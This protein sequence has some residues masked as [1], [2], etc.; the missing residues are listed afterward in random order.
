MEEGIWT[1]VKHRRHREQVKQRLDMVTVFVNNLPEDM[2]ETLGTG[3]WARPQ[4]KKK[5]VPINTPIG[6]KRRTSSSRFGELTRKETSY[7]D[8]VRGAASRRT[9]PDIPIIKGAFVDNEWLYR[10]AVATFKDDI[11]LG[12]SFNSFTKE[13]GGIA[14]TRQLGNKQVL[15]TF[16]SLELLNQALEDK[17]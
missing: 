10:S 5:W 1:L 15:I 12:A 7:V 2:D 6:T 4:M 11:S 3:N 8:A 13:E 9:I 16:Q 17:Q 14:D